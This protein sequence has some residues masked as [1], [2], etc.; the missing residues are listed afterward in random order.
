MRRN[1]NNSYGTDLGPGLAGGPMIQRLWPLA[2]IVVGFLATPAQAAPVYFNVGSCVTGDCNSYYA[3]GGGSIL[4]ELDI[5]NGTDLLITLTN[6]LNRNAV[7]DDPYLTN[8]GFDYSGIL[9]GLTFDSFT[10]LSGIVGTPRFTVDSSIRSFF[11]D[12]GF[13][14]SDSGRASEVQNRFQAMDPNEV[15]QIV[16][17]TNSTINLADFTLAVAKV[18]GTGQDGRGSAAVLVGRGA[19]VASVPEPTSLLLV[20]LGVTVFGVRRR[21]V[22]PIAG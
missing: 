22:V 10:V 1:R 16:V 17:G 4:A 18:G 13:G 7:N 12:F 8:L 11:I 2:L 21:S 6:D 14:F 19:D 15:V 20:G 9:S 3:S 5:L